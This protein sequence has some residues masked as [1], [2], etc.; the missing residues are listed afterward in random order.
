MR[1]QKTHCRRGHLYTKDTE[2]WRIQNGTPNRGCKV[3]E[4]ITDLL[5]YRRT[6]YKKLTKYGR[7]EPDSRFKGGPGS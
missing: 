2:R 3:C 7:G 4:R 1:A 6:G 5:W